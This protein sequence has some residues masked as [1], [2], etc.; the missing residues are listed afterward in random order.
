[1][2][3]TIIFIFFLSIYCHKILGQHNFP[4]LKYQNISKSYLGGKI[5][6]NDF[7][8]FELINKFCDENDN[9]FEYESA[10]TLLGKFKLDSKSEIIFYYTE[11]PSDDPTFYAVL[12]GKMI[13]ISAGKIIH[14]KGKTI[15]TEGIANSYIN[16]K[17][18]FVFEEGK[19]IE[20]KQPFY[21]VGLKGKLNHSI[22]LFE[23]ENFHNKVASLPKGYD[24]E[25]IGGK[26]GGEYELLEKVLIKTE[27]GLVGWLNFK[28]FMNKEP[29]IDN[30]IF[31]G[32]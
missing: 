16:R 30:F 19:Y 29:L 9:C 25:I 14:I 3:K 32:D 1:M 21:Y 27:F 31:W 6:Y 28:P 26:I 10:E 5:G 15:Y 18:K 7:S 4:D 24:I 23:S 12:N 17:K 20:V 8:N 2:K 13:F 11:A 22:S